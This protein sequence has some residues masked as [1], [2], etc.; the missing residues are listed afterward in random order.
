MTEMHG[1]SGASCEDGATCP[2]LPYEIPSIGLIE[3]THGS[4]QA[5]VCGQVGGLRLTWSRIVVWS[6]ILVGI[7]LAGAF[8]Q[9]LY[10][11]HSGDI[12]S[13]SFFMGLSGLDRSEGP[14]WVVLLDLVFMPPFLGVWGFIV[15]MVFIALVNEVGGYIVAALAA[16]GVGETFGLEVGKYLL[17]EQVERGRANSFY[18][19]EASGPVHLT[20]GDT[21][22]SNPWAAAIGLGAVVLAVLDMLL[23]RNKN[24]VRRTVGINV[25]AAIGLLGLAIYDGKWGSILILVLLFVVVGV[26]LPAE[27]YSASFL[28]EHQY[29][30]RTAKG[31]GVVLAGELAA[32]FA[33]VLFTMRY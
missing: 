19:V 5:K 22:F 1:E 33:L 27:A 20:A 17:L 15:S 2:R 8:G 26:L 30:A 21:L 3:A 24:L 23:L 4:G 11:T 16:L 7:M 32:V 31:V 9:S 13:S 25:L 28:I 14:L 18:Q 29:P 10:M 6:L 12:T